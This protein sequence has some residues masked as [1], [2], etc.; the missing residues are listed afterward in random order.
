MLNTLNSQWT[1][2]ETH[3]TLSPKLSIV[4]FWDDIYKDSSISKSLGNQGSKMFY[5]YLQKAHNTG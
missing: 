4:F 2:D 1:L 5:L 3:G